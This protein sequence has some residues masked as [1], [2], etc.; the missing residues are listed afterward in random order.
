MKIFVAFFLLFLLLSACKRDEGEDQGGT[1]TFEEIMLQAVSDG[2]AYFQLQPVSLPSYIYTVNDT[3]INKIIDMV[4]KLNQSIQLNQ[5][6]IT[7]KGDG[8]TRNNSVALLAT[9]LQDKV[10]YTTSCFDSPVPGCIF[11][12]YENDGK[13][14]VKAYQYNYPDS[15]LLY[16]TYTGT[17]SRNI[18]YDDE[19]IQMW[20]TKKDLSIS[21]YTLYNKM[22]LCDTKTITLYSFDWRVEDQGAELCFGGDCNNL[23]TTHYRYTIW[24]CDQINNHHIIFSETLT[25][26]PDETVAFTI[27][28]YSYLKKEVYLWIHFYITRDGK[29]CTVMYNDQGQIELYDCN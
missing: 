20:M 8:N 16:I 24:G 2:K 28:T 10:K 3:M 19:F 12:W 9:S 14:N 4:S 1:A 21:Q 27:S 11:S 25:I 6:P 26:S 5:N 7:T 18:S 15:W 17:D 23:A 29:Y 13:L 22:P